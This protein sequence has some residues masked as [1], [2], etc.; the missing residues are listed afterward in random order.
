MADNGFT[1]QAVPP[2]GLG[3]PPAAGARPLNLF[4]VPATL[5]RETGVLRIGLVAL[6]PQEEMDGWQ[7]GGG[8]G[9]P[10][11]LAAQQGLTSLREVT[12]S[13]GGVQALSLA[14]GTVER[15][16]NTTDPRIR[17]LVLLAFTAVHHVQEE[18]EASFLGSRQVR[19]G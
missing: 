8:A 2:G 18:D 5:A 11:G 4:N 13:D 6:T 10:M 7:R 17:N 19:V 9:R 14:D 16:W 3:S 15:F 1:P 12:T